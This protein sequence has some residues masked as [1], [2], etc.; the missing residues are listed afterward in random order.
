MN[1]GGIKVCITLKIWPLLTVELS[2]VCLGAW[3]VKEYKL[4]YLKVDFSSDPW[5]PGLYALG[6]ELWH[7]I[8]TY[9]EM[10]HLCQM[11]CI[12]TGNFLKRSYQI[13]QL[14]CFVCPKLATNGFFSLHLDHGIVKGCFWFLIWSMI[15]VGFVNEKEIDAETK[16]KYSF[17]FLLLPF[18]WQIFAV[19]TALG[20]GTK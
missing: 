19:S 10:I 11:A 9:Y 16:N 4:C 8:A 7:Y 13:I 17:F 2:R 6:L 12:M 1:L 15:S 3:A 18:P 20:N 5:S 14:Y